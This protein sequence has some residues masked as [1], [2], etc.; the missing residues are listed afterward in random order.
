LHDKKLKQQKEA[1]GAHTQGSDFAGP[2]T[3]MSC[4]RAHRHATPR[5]GPAQLLYIMISR[6]AVTFKIKHGLIIIFIRVM[7][8]GI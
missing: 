4:A 7:I 8:L 3:R 1:A 2:F 6:L 5:P